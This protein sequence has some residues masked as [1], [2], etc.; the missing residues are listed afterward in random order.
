[1]QRHELMTARSTKMA[2]N[3]QGMDRD[4]ARKAIVADLEKRA[5]RL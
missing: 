1:M 4:E 5:E 2:E 3:M